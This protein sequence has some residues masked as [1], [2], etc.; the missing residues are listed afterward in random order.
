MLIFHLQVLSSLSSNLESIAP[1]R[2][3]LSISLLSISKLCVQT[4][5]CSQAYSSVQCDSQFTLTNKQPVLSYRPFY[6][7]FVY[8]HQL[9][10]LFSFQQVLFVQLS[11][12]SNVFQLVFHLEIVHSFVSLLL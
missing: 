1:Y 12:R 4:F 5:I 3:F 7:Y 8:F 2:T 11:E 10:L 6:F 9:I